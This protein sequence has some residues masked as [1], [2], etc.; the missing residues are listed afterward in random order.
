MAC[1]QASAA[2]RSAS[3]C[4]V[5]KACLT[6][7]ARLNIKHS[8]ASACPSFRRYSSPPCCTHFTKH[9]DSQAHC[10]H[11]CQAVMDCFCCELETI[12]SFI[13][14]STPAIGVCVGLCMTRAVCGGLQVAVSTVTDSERLLF[15]KLHYPGIYRCV[16]RYGYC[17]RVDRGTMFVIKLL[18]KVS[19][20]VLCASSSLVVGSGGAHLGAHISGAARV[21]VALGCGDVTSLAARCTDSSSTD[22]SATSDCK[23]R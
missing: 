14:G 11:R 13:V 20:W 22:N 10:Q 15:R 1:S 12:Q 5:S 19:N 4:H 2:I 8:D 16:A 6:V 7:M 3:V 17:D 9:I 21:L 23:A 18:D